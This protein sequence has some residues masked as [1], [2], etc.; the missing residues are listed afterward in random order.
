MQ[1]VRPVSDLRNKFT[2]I[3]E[4]VH[5]SGRPVILTRNGRGD[6]VVM[7]MESFEELSFHS[8][9]LAALRD[10]ER[11]AAVTEER[12]SLDEVLAEARAVVA[13]S[14]AVEPDRV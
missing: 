13:G 14:V 2:E 10:A 3:S 5:E 7:S 12:F 8:E 6:M 1:S 11:E 4:D 9:V